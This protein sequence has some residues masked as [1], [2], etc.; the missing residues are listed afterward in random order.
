MAALTDP[1]VD[2]NQAIE[3]VANED[4]LELE[5]VREFQGDVDQTQQSLFHSGKPKISVQ[6]R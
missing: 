6:L 3:T 1:F 5:R 4:L 2:R